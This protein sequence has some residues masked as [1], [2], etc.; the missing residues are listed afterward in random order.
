MN[1]DILT[2]GLPCA[3]EFGHASPCRPTINFGRLIHDLRDRMRERWNRVL[4]VGDL[5]S[6][7]WEKARYLGWGEGSSVYD[8][9]LVLGDV[10]VGA[11]TWVGPF[12]VLDGSGGLE[13]GDHCSISAG[14]HIYSHDSVRHALSGGVE[15]IE[16][17]PTRI[18]S[19]CYLGPHAVVCKGVTI[20]DGCVVGAHSV[21]M[22]DLPPGSKAYG[23]PAKV[24]GT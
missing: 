5:L 15:P 24:R 4:P 7:R 11:G 20:G 21:V 3:L 10:R 18:G 8:S 1:C 22:S 6:D 9:C 13:V 12:T 19:R 23:A 16:R 17:S 14:V 2:F